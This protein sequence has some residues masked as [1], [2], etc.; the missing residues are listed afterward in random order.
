[1]GP[2]SWTMN[3]TLVKTALT[4]YIE[5]IVITFSGEINLRLSP[6]K[7]KFSMRSSNSIRYIFTP[8]KLFS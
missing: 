3:R 1:M 4:P 2:S 5:R 6:F 7:Q 8:N